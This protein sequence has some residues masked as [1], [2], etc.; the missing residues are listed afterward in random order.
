MTQAESKS[1]LQLPKAGDIETALTKGRFKCAMETASVSSDLTVPRGWQ[2]GASAG[3]D[4][5][6]LLARDNPSRGLGGIAQFKQADAAIVQIIDLE[7]G[8]VLRTMAEL[9]AALGLP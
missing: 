9:R 5:L 1:A 6:E 2:H 8:N 7:T 4:W 3:F